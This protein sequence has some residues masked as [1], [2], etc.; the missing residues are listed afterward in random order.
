[1]LN[2]DFDH[3]DAYPEPTYVPE[4]TFWWIII[5]MGIVLLVLIVALI[6]KGL[7]INQLSNEI[8]D[9]K[10]ITQKSKKEISLEDISEQLNELRKEIH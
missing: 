3:I 6:I 2:L 1:M 9:L 7:Q 5:I 10:K 4:T 8:S